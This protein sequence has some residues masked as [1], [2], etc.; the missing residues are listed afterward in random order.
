[1]PT[2]FC[3]AHVSVVFAQLQ[4]V[5]GAAGEHA[6]RFTHAFGNEVVYQHTQI[7]FV[8]TGHPGVAG[9]GQGRPFSGCP[10]LGLGL[11]RRVDAGEQ[12]LRRRFFVTGGAVDLPSK[13]QAADGFGLEAAFQPSRVEV[14]VFNGVTGPQDVG[15]FQPGHRTH[16]LVL[17]VKRQAGGNAVGVILVGRQPFRLQKNLVAVF[18]GESVDF[19]FHARAITRPHAVDLAGEHGAA[20][21]AAADDVVG[22][23]VGVGNPT[24]HLRRVH[25]HLAHEAEHGHGR[26]VSAFHA[27]AR[28][29]LTLAEVNRAA[30]QARRC[31]GLQAALRQFQ[32]FQ[33]RTQG[34]CGW[35]ARS[36]R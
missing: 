23:F 2:D 4:A 31:A 3:E 15:V 18:A 13:K 33:A 22:A 24:R 34:D 36:A 12:A 35:V 1:M 16:Q 6:V 7:G 25:R 8:A 10:G 14:V 32:L 28:L 9:A 5:L 29:A 21:E 27:I 19:V 20:V 11:Q 17:N 30:I 26:V